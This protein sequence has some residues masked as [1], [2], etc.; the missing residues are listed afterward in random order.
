MEYNASSEIVGSWSLTDADGFTWYI[1]F[2]GDK[3]WKITDGSSPSSR[4]RVYGTYGYS[5]GKFSGNMKN[6]N[7]GEGEIAGT[8]AG[9]MISLGFV[10]FWHTPHK[11][12]EYT[13]SRLP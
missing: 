9:N 2:G 8:I 10:E 7:V 11:K 3:S 1:H 5:N 4:L 13:G 12:I 6:D